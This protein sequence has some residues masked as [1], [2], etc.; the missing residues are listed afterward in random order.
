LDNTRVL[1]EEMAFNEEKVME[2]Y[3]L[4][5]KKVLKYAG[6][7]KKLAEEEK[8]HANMLKSFS[9][10]PGAGGI[11]AGLDKVTMEIIR[12]SITFINREIEKAKKIK[13]EAKEAFAMAEKI[14]SSML[15]NEIF[16]VFE[17]TDK[18]LK[19]LLA[20]LQADTKRHFEQVKRLAETAK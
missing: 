8:K 19:K 3:W 16:S 5:E 9:L 10:L 17:S 20:T 7:W 11:K 12:K 14:E 18:D 1:L 4:Y 15:E 2:L 13:V 6:M